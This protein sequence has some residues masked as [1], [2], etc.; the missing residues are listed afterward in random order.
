[1]NMTQVILKQLGIFPTVTTDQLYRL[2][3]SYMGCI[4]SKK[5]K[6]ELKHLI[7]KGLVEMVVTDTSVRYGLVT[8]DTKAKAFAKKLLEA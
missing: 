1:M 3:K 5:F 4:S 8:E 7:S 2:V 6:I